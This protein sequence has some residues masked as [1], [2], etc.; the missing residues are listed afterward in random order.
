MTHTHT[1]KVVIK[2]TKETHNHKRRI[3]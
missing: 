2:L 3:W 1:H